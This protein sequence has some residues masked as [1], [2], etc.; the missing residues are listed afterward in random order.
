MASARLSVRIPPELQK[1]LDALVAAAGTSE[2][3]VVRAALTEYCQKHAKELTAYEVAQE[4]GVLGCV[5]GGPSDRSTH[6]RHMDGFGR[7]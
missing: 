1:S 5:S 4:A 7:G 6:P 3:E 2:A